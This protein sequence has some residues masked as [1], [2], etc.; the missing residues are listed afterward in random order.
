MKDLSAILSSEKFSS[1]AVFVFSSSSPWKPLLGQNTPRVTHCQQ[2]S[3]NIRSVTHCQQS[4]DNIRSVTHCQQSS[5]NVRSVTHCQQS[6]DNVR[7]VTHCQQSS[8]SVR[9]VTHCQQSSDNVRSV[10]HCQQS[11]DQCQ[12]GHSLRHTSHMHYGD[13]MTLQWTWTLGDMQYLHICVN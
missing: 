5:D 7:S 2:S 9:S 11:S 10:T 8:D 1:I 6:S 13:T 4:S 3:D 12:I